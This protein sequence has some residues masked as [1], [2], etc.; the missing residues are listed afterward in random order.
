MRENKDQRNS[1]YKH[2][3]R[4][5]SEE[6]LPIENDEHGSSSEKPIQLNKTDYILAQ[7]KSLHPKVDQ[8]EKRNS[9]SLFLKPSIYHRF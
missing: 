7:I 2:F 3:S 9:S 1:K 5:V 4:S 8:L 6:D